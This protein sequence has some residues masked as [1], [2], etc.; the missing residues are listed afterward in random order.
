MSFQV[1]NQL[2]QSCLSWRVKCPKCKTK[3]FELNCRLGWGEWCGR[4]WRRRSGG[5]KKE[6]KIDMQMKTFDFLMSVMFKLLST[7]KGSSEKKLRF[8]YAFIMSDRGSQCMIALS[9]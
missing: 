8:F 5:Y 3:G 2:L 6:S 4:E 9:R 1:Y 7:I